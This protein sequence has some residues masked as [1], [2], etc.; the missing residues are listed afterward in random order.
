[1]NLTQ[2]AVSATA[3]NGGSESPIET[4][5]AQRTTGL[6]LGEP[7]AFGKTIGASV[8]SCP[9]YHGCVRSLSAYLADQQKRDRDDRSLTSRS[10][11]RKARKDTESAFATL[12][13]A[14]CDC[15]EKQFKRL[16]LPEALRDLVLEARRIDSP[17]ARDRALRLVRRELRDG[18][19]AAVQ[20]QLSALEKPSRASRASEQWCNRLID[21]REPALNEFVNQY[22]AA[23]RQQLRL[24]VRNV[25]KASA[26]Q[27]TKAVAA[28]TRCVRA[29]MTAAS[30]CDTPKLEH[31]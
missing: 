16:E 24:L 2:S 21:E 14:L 6:I 29:S 1:M 8:V 17:A 9:C 23:D 3:Q 13:R 15:S 4:L 28:L 19:A 27:R 18:D 12:A 5:K 7:W 20:Q 31:D 30:D 11:L 25:A 22:P 26:E 10:D